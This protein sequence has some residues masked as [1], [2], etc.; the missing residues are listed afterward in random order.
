[1]LLHLP[2]QSLQLCIYI[3]LVRLIPLRDR[4]GRF[5]K[6]SLD[7]RFGFGVL[8][9]IVVVQDLTLGGG[10][11]SE[12]GVDV[13]RALV[14]LQQSVLQIKGVGGERWTYQN[15]GTDL[16]DMFGLAVAVQIVVLNLE[17]LAEGYENREGEVISGLV[18]DTDLI[19]DQLSPYTSLGDQAA[20]S[21]PHA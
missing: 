2:D 19:I 11:V 8:A 7:T 13:P 18:G 12:G 14:V 20:E 16:A 6:Q 1:L 10:G 17:V 3:R 21:L 5:G 9:T 15:V 4:D